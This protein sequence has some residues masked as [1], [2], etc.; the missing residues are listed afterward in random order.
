MNHVHLTWFLDEVE[1]IT[2]SESKTYF[3]LTD[4]AR[5]DVVIYGDV[6]ERLFNVFV[7]LIPKCIHP[8][9]LRVVRLGVGRNGT[10]ELVEGCPIESGEQNEI[11]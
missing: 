9:A 10:E 5:N 11:M 3:S 8:R 7:E 4:G 2:Q 1:S 6:D